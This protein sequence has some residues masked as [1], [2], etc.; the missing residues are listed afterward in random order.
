MW[1]LFFLALSCWL[2]GGTCEGTLRTSGDTMS[3]TFARLGRLRL[4]LFSFRG[5][6]LYYRLEVA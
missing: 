5:N 3:C 1:T 4:A 2:F 6:R